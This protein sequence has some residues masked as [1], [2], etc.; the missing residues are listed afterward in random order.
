M[1]LGSFGAELFVGAVA[2]IWPA[3]ISHQSRSLII[4][5]EWEEGKGGGKGRQT[6]DHVKSS[7]PVARHSDSCPKIVSVEAVRR[8][9]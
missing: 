9:R 7:Y 5:V 4:L 8:D 6:K 3:G 2:E 1:V